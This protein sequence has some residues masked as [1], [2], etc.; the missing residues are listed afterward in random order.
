MTKRGIQKIVTELDALPG[1]DGEKLHARADDIILNALPEEVRA[2][3]RR[4]TERAD[5]WAGA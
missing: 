1:T 4:V 5:F 3:Y 2:A